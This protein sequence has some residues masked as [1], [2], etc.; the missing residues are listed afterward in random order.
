MREE[1]KLRV[2]EHTKRSREWL[3]N[4]IRQNAATMEERQETQPVSGAS[5]PA[6]LSVDHPSVRQT[7]KSK[8]KAPDQVEPCRSGNLDSSREHG[9]ARQPG[10]QELAVGHPAQQARARTVARLIKELNTIKAQLLSEDL[11]EYKRLRTQYRDFLVFG[12]AEQRPDLQ[13]KVLA[14]SGSTRHIR[15]AQELAGA[16]HGR[17]LSTIQQ[18]WKHFKPAE[19]RRDG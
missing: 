5:V 13:T 18:D 17:E 11:D 4:Q 9:P 12:I 2:H 16:Q 3:E 15:L 14:I 10:A 6:V 19:F 7:R 8:S 1:K